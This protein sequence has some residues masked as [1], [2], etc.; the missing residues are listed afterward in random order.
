MEKLLIATTNPGKLKEYKELLRGLPLKLISLKDVGVEKK[1]EEDGKNFKENAIKKAEFYSQLTNLLTLSDDG[2]LEIDYL[3]GEPGV[4]SHRWPGHEA[5]DEELLNFTLKKMEGVPWKKRGAQL[6]VV[7][8]LA[9]PGKK[10]LTSEGKIRGFILT[11]PRE[12]I[13]PG[14]PF[15]SI[16]YLPQYRRSFNQLTPEE[17][18][19]I[20]H[21]KKAIRQIIKFLKLEKII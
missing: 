17:E 1:V 13:I 7:I 6:K 18:L 8:A 9:I 4:T 12:K 16:F 3:N 14:Y 20:S 2:G 11:K 19:K 21:R 5:N 15:R 10:I